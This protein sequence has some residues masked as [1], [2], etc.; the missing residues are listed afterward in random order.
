MGAVVCC[1]GGCS[2]KATFAIYYSY[3]YYSHIAKGINL[4]FSK[5]VKEEQSAVSIHIIIISAQEYYQ[6]WCV[7]IC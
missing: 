6:G 3:Y 5:I 4:V 1:I 2:C 7:W